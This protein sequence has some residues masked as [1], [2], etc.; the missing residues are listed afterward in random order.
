MTSIIQSIELCIRFQS[1][2]HSFVRSKYSLQKEDYPS[3]R[4]TSDDTDDTRFTIHR[5]VFSVQ[6]NV[7]ENGR[8]GNVR[9]DGYIYPLRVVSD[10]DDGLEEPKRSANHV[11]ARD[12][13]EMYC[14]PTPE[15]VCTTIFLRNLTG[16]PLGYTKDALG[17]EL[18]S[19]EIARILRSDGD[20]SYCR[21][22]TL[23]TIIL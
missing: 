6:R 15:N 3:V 10:V 18:I 12:T 1:A 4:C 2:R 19:N 14:A 13:G 9:I 8:E 7:S 16:Y 5:Q 17:T 22:E 11:M 21:A 23:A 20:I